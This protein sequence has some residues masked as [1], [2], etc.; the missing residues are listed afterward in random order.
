[1]EAKTIS[2]ATYSSPGVGILAGR[3]RGERARKEEKLDSLDRAEE[4]EVTVVIPEHIY[5]VN[6]SFFL[7]MFDRSIRALGAEGFRRRYKFVG[8]DADSMR[9]EGIRMALLLGRPFRPNVAGA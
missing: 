9:D 7:G 2:L 3:D 4:V 5:S 1:M 8:P 6:S